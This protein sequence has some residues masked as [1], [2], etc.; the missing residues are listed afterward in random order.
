[1][2]N[3]YLAEYIGSIFIMYI[4]LVTGNP[5]AIG[6]AFAIAIT[7]TL[8]ISGGMFNPMVAIVMAVAGK[9]PKS[10]I[11]SRII[12]QIAGGLTALELTKLI[13]I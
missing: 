1:M 11:L 9:I 3:K 6:I 5:I 4:I 10:E 2:L 13:K 7:L 8:K 12:A